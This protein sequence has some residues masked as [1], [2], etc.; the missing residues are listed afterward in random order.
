M[1]NTKSVSLVTLAVVSLYSQVSAA[2]WISCL[3]VGAYGVNQ[4]SCPKKLLPD[5]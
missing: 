4:D 3:T 5:C 1:T 2:T